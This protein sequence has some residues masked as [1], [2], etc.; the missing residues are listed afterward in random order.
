MLTKIYF[1]TWLVI[2]IAFLAM[3]I[4]GGMTMAAMVVF[5]F[6]AFG[7]VFMGIM[8][9]LP[10]EV[11]HSHAKPERAMSI[12]SREPTPSPIRHGVHSVQV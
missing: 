11:S 12:V 1:S 3:F 4:A 2:A 7:M 5:G 8:G 10:A 9:V 6:I